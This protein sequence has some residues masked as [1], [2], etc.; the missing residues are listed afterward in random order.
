MGQVSS[1]TAPKEKHITG[2]ITERQPRQVQIDSSISPTTGP[3]KRLG[4]V[5][6]GGVPI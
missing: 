6:H 5:F 1:H 2:Q 4:K 3:N